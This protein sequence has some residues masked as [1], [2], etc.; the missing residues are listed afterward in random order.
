MTINV[1]QFCFWNLHENKLPMALNL[2]GIS[3]Q[4]TILFFSLYFRIPTYDEI[5]GEE[6][7]TEVLSVPWTEL[8]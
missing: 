7:D 3:L 5:I 6:D 1:H 4:L 8:Y 2:F